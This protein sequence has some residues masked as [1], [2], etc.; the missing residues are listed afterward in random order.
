MIGTDHSADDLSSHSR[1]SSVREQALSHFLLWQ[2]TAARW[3]DGRHDIEVLKSEADLG[4]YD[5]VLEANA[6][7]R[8]VQLKSTFAGSKVREVSVSTRLLEKPSGCV[9]WLEIDRTT[10]ALQRY[11]WFG[12]KPGSRLPDLGSRASHHSRANSNGYKSERPMHRQLGKSCFEAL[13]SVEDLL[14]RLFG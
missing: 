12:G 10:L 14:G 13:A 5:I 4:G 1:A 7:I 9:V 2:L 8:H 3:R 6:I 11:L